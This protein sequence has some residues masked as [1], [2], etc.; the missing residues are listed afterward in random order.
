MDH[1]SSSITRLDDNNKTIQGYWG[2]YPITGTTAIIPPTGYYFASVTAQADSV[3]A[4]LQVN[5]ASYTTDSYLT[6]TIYSG[7]WHPFMAKVTS[8]A[9]TSGVLQA[10]LKPL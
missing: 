8:I 1:I 4:S 7:Q 10:W 2:D 6:K 5:G 9:L 3:I